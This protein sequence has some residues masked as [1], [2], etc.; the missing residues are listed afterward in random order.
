MADVALTAKPRAKPAGLNARVPA[1]A[2]RD[3]PSPPAGPARLRVATA[4][5]LRMSASNKA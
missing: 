2:C 5:P 4:T 3:P 1:A